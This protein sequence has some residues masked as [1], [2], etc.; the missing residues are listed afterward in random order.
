MTLGS[1]E[2]SVLSKTRTLWTE[3]G[4]EKGKGMLRC[5]FEAESPLSL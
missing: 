2:R 5:A 1:T 3:S 4:L